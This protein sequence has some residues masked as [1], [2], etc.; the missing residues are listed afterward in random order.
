VWKKKGKISFGAMEPLC[1]PAFGNSN[2]L[3]NDGYYNSH[4][5]TVKDQKE[6][7]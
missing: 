1:R 6:K 7:K 2:H 5:K 3:P 4:T